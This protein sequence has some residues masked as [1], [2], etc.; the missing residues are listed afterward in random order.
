M[1]RIIE[2]SPK[3]NQLDLNTKVLVSSGIFIIDLSKVSSFNAE[4]KQSLS[5]DL[6]NF[7]NHEK[8]DVYLWSEWRYA[9]DSIASLEE[10]RLKLSSNT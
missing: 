1:E 6:L 10:V 8:M 4:A 2:C 3:N 7:I 9:I 5:P